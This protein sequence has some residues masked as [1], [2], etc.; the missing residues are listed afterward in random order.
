MW[1]GVDNLN[2][3]DDMTWLVDGTKDNTIAWCIDVPYHRKVVPEVSRA[4]WTVYSTNT[5]NRMA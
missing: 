2:G 1:G 3:T 4:G 5:D